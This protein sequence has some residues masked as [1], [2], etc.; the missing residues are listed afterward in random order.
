MILWTAP[1]LGY[2]DVARP[3]YTLRIVLEVLCLPQQCWESDNYSSTKKTRG[4]VQVRAGQDAVYVAMP[5]LAV[6]LA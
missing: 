5:W 2:S 4:I 3:G 1:A 6:A